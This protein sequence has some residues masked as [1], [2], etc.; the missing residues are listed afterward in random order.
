MAVWRSPGLEAVIGGPLDVQ[1][2]TEAAIDRFVA[3]GTAESDQLEFKG[4]LYPAGKGPRPRWSEEQEF[5]K[6]ASA[7]ANHRGGMIIVGV[8]EVGGIASGTSPLAATLATELE[9]R[10]LRQALANFQAPIGSCDFVWVPTQ[11]GE[12][13]LAV[14]VPPSPRQPHAVLGDRGDPR[15]TLRYPVRHGADTRFLSE[16]E[17]AERYWRRVREGE[18]ERARAKRVVADGC[19]ML[20]RGVGVWLY[21]A[22]VPESVVPGTLDR[23]AV[24]RIENW[25]RRWSLNSPLERSLPA[26]GRAMPSP[27]RVTFAGALSSSQ[28]DEA[29]IQGAYV[30]LHV[31]GSAFAARSVG[32]SSSGNPSDRDTGVLS[33]VDDTILLVDVA[34]RWAAEQAGAWGTAWVVIGLVDADSNDGALAKPVQVVTSAYGEVCRRPGTRPVHGRP[35]AETVADLAAVDTIQQRLAISYQAAAGLLQWFGLAEPDQLRPDG[36]IVLAGFS[37]SQSRQALEWAKRNSVQTEPATPA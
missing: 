8:N 27:G 15:P 35:N 24:Q 3:E 33:L 20:C 26:H 21:V 6:D 14:V 2:I 9:E 16:A 17:V 37:Y 25:H 29:H 13:F 4:G 19:G 31:D 23:G 32:A 30:E 36:T 10:R 7:F 34:V 5:A 28:E 1:G 18:G 12:W 11:T 22:V